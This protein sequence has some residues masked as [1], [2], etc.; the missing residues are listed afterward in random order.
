MDSRVIAKLVL[1]LGH[2]T[3]GEGSVKG[4]TPTQWTA[5]RYFA[6]ANRFS[7]T[8]ASKPWSVQRIYPPAFAATSPTPC[9]PYSASQQPV[10]LRVL[11]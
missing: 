3:S 8:T 10:R 7:R 6:R 2:M 4:L 9:S 1:H 5:L 11:I